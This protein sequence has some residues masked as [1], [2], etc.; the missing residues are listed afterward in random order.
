MG[1]LDLVEQ[2][3]RLG[4]L[5]QRDRQPP[6]AVAA[7]V[8]RAGPISRATDGLV[9]QLRHVHPDHPGGRAE[10]V[11]GQEPRGLGLAHAA[12]AHEQQH[13]ART[14][15][16]RGRRQ[17]QP[18]P[19]GDARGR[20]VLPEH[21]LAQVVLEREQPSPHSGVE[22]LGH[23]VERELA[24]LGED[25][26]DRERRDERRVRRARS[27]TQR[28]RRARPLGGLVDELD[29]LLRELAVGL[30]AHRQVDRG[31]Q[32]LVGDRDAALAL[33][34]RTQLAQLLQRLVAAGPVERGRRRAGAE[35]VGALAR[36][37]QRRAQRGRLRPA[38][39][40]DAGGDDVHV[41]RQGREQVRDT[42]ALG[43]PREV[44]GGGEDGLARERA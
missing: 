16:A 42:D 30:E 15:P 31:H 1:L 22:R 26:R 36:L 3:Q 37:E 34:A 8:A 5:P 43:G 35:H 6:F 38:G 24:P 2:Q 18:Q 7:G 12:R 23:E 33:E 19:P 29:R 40:D 32:R 17:R 41:L 13:R 11:L 28:Q 25:A 27:L 9:A 14:L 44:G 10:E 39:A 20:L 21:A 4:L